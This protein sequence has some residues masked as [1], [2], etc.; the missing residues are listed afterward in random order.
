M[1]GIR[2]R[3]NTLF[4]VPRPGGNIN[5]NANANTNIAACY[6][7]HG[8]QCRAGNCL[9]LFVRLP[10]GRVRSR[11]PRFPRGRRTYDRR[12]P[13]RAPSSVPE[14]P[15]SSAARLK[16]VKL[17]V[18]TPAPSR[19]YLHRLLITTINNIRDWRR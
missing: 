7:C 9:V 19:Y 6:L 2:F 5:V 10:V 18:N 16:R 8:L 14:V 11:A 1:G 17:T 3:D 15:R 12:D 13:T 4:E